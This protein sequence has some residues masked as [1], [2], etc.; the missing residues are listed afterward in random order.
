MPCL[1][2]PLGHIADEPPEM[3]SHAPLPHLHASADATAFDARAVA[4]DMPYF[5]SAAPDA[6]LDWRRQALTCL[7]QHYGFLTFLYLNCLQAPCTWPPRNTLCAGGSLKK[8]CK[9]HP[10]NRIRLLMMFV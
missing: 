8:A 1:Q 5:H 2:Y 4:T 10:M 6:E 3:S 9:P 7:S